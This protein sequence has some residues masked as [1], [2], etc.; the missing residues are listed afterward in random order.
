MQNR[1]HRPR[2][3]TIIAILTIISGIMLLLS[4]IALVALGALFSGNSTS[5]SSQAI[6]QFF[7]VIS[8]Q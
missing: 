8:A 4:G 2:G 3:V 1:Q 7:G 5:T 6:A